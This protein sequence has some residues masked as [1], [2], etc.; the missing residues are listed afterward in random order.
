MS[1]SNNRKEVRVI[2]ELEKLV[3]AGGYFSTEAEK[4]AASQILRA[5]EGLRI[6]DAKELLGHCAKVL[7][8]MEIHY[9]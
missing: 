9:K 5:L 1:E 8:L 6:W 4:K 2:T 3:D 7:D